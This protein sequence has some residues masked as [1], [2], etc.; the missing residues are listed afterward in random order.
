MCLLFNESVDILGDMFDAFAP[1]YL[2]VNHSFIQD[3]DD[4]RDATEV[5]MMCC[6]IKAI[7]GWHV[8]YAAN[9]TRERCGGAGY[10]SANR[11]ACL[12]TFYVENIHLP[13]Y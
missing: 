11:S 7:T 4:E 1:H 10:L 3:K 12:R 13:I 8:N 9:L 2:D 5:V 6:A